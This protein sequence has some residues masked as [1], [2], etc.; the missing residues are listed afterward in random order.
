MHFLFYYFLQFC[1]TLLPTIPI[2]VAYG[3]LHSNQCSQNPLIGVL[4]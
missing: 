2:S 1:S 3:L 4:Q